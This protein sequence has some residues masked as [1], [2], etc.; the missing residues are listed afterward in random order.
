MTP[1]QIQLLRE[2]AINALAQ[3]EMVASGDKSVR[4]RPVADM[5]MALDLLRRESAAMT[6]TAAS[7]IVLIQTSRG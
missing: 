4:N 6:R 7:R 1:E 3:P 2:K 5:L